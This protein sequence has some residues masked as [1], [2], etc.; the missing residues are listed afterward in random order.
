MRNR[1]LIAGWAF[2]QGRDNNVIEKVVDDGKTYFVIRDYQA[3]RGLFGKQLREIQRIKS[4]G[5]FEAGKNLIETY[6]VKV[7]QAIHEEVLARAEPLNIAPYKGFIQPRIVAVEENGEIVDVRVEH[8]QD[9]VERML[10]LEDNY[11]FLPIEN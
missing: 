4:E 3:L 7:D 10:E 11:S 2:E 6:G 1:Q 9:F 8:P 5:D